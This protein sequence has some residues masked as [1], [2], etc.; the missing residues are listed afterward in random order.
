MCN[1]RNR[2]PSEY[3]GYGLYFYFSGLSLRRTSERLS[4]FIKRNHVSVWNW[5]QKYN[6]RKI[7]SKKKKV[8]EFIV[9][10]TLIKVGSE[11]IWLWVAVEP[12]DKE[13]LAISISKERNMFVAERF[14]SS[15]VKGYGEHPVS[16][17][18]GTWYP[19]ACR[20]L[21]LQ[22]HLHSPFEKSII[23]RTMQYIK[24]RT[25]GFDDYFPCRK[26]NCKLKHVIN[27]LNLFVDYHN[28]EME[29]VK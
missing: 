4:H 2:T 24:D 16:T 11:F 14:L 7:S 26:K 27:W 22:H 29:I 13:I 23:E 28:R 25:E 5:I 12:N 6:P 1:K 3:I 15:V 20:F 10:E 17:D 8:D 18:G 9:D 21:K 19:Q